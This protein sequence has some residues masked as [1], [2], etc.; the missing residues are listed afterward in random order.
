MANLVT[1]SASCRVMLHRHCLAD[2]SL[3]HHKVRIIVSVLQIEET[4]THVPWPGAPNWDLAQ[5]NL[6]PKSC[7]LYY[8]LSAERMAR[9]DMA[10]VEFQ[11][12]TAK[13]TLQNTME[14]RT[15]RLCVGGSQV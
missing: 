15:K 3:L 7:F 14:L 13:Y 11:E 10:G 6:R 9:G 5:E 12:L 2:C 8:T 1:Y 4:K